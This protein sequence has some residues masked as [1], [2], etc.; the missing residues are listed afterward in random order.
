M[1]EDTER[2]VAVS[3]A[4]TTLQNVT[5]RRVEHWSRF[6]ASIQA[7]PFVAHSEQDQPSTPTT[8]SL[9]RGE[10]PTSWIICVGCARITTLRGI[11]GIVPTH[12]YGDF[13]VTRTVRSRSQRSSSGWSYDFDEETLAWRP[14][15]PNPRGAGARAKGVASR[16]VCGRRR[17]VPQ[18]TPR[19][20]GPLAPHSRSYQHDGRPRPP[21]SSHREGGPRLAGVPAR[22]QVGR[23]REGAGQAHPRAPSRPSYRAVES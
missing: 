12:N 11:M 6:T 15:L 5:I 17:R 16:Y 20:L 18:R 1:E 9:Y 8:S 23:R 2:R 22:T 7:Y 3:R 4:L 10:G 19:L 21:L 13:R 14:I